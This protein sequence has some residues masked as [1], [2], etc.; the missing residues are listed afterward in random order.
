MYL[1]LIHKLAATLQNLLI[2]SLRA[3]D[4]DLAIEA[5]T[6]VDPDR[7]SSLISWFTYLPV[8]LLILAISGVFVSDSKSST[9]KVSELFLPIYF[10]R[11]GFLPTK[12]RIMM[13]NKKGLRE[14][15]DLNDEDKFPEPEPIGAN[16]LL[17]S[18]H[19]RDLSVYQ[20]T[21]VMP[22]HVPKGQLIR[23]DFGVLPGFKD[24][25][26]KQRESTLKNKSQNDFTI[27]GEVKKCWPA[28]RDNNTYMAGVKFI[29]LEKDT[30]SYLAYYVNQ[31]KSGGRL[32]DFEQTIKGIS[33]TNPSDCNSKN[34]SNK[35]NEDMTIRENS[36]S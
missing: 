16:E 10:R 36:I 26:D 19:L 30:R 31:L 5:I 23:M 27:V 17:T 34:K 29:G 13:K 24:V 25:W 35:I 14:N 7:S 11:L 9:T 33:D 6:S 12:F 18:A 21:I 4:L 3:E 22:I 2:P 1:Y 15:M 8:M 20:A 32:I 28:D